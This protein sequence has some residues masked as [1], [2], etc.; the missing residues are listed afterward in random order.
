[1]ADS[2]PSRATARRT[3]AGLA[4]EELV[5]GLL[6]GLGFEGLRVEGFGIRV[7]GLRVEGFGIRV[8]DLGLKV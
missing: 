5:L 2:C 7:E 8:E 3:T 1:M 4:W 6:D